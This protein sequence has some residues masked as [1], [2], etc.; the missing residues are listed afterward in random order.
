MNLI[1]AAHNVKLAIT[2]IG[3]GELPEEDAQRR[4]IVM[5]DLD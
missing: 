5:L 3:Q 4:S 1:N 2:P